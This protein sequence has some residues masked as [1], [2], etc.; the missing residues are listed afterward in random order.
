MLDVLNHDVHEAKSLLEEGN[1]VN[2]T[3]QSFVF[4]PR[5]VLCSL[6]FNL[7]NVEALCDGSRNLQ[8]LYNAG[9]LHQIFQAFKQISESNLF[10]ETLLQQF[11]YRLHCELPHGLD[12][13][14]VG[15]ELTLVLCDGPED[16]QPI[17]VIGIGLT[18][19]LDQGVCL[20]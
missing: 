18:C 10:P 19:L 11:N 2:L 5:S 7:I 9:A 4:A 12:A 3:G 20:E 13:L 1:V 15:A 17:Q 6:F 8:A 14:R 16:R